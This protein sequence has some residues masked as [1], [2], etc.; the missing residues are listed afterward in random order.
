MAVLPR[1]AW[2]R[3]AISDP[4][5][6]QNCISCEIRLRPRLF[7]IDRLLWVL[8]PIAAALS[9]RDGVGQAG[10]CRPIAPSWIPPALAMAFEIRAVWL[11]AKD[12]R[13]CPEFSRGTSEIRNRDKMRT[14][15]RFGPNSPVSGAVRDANR[16]QNAQNPGK[17]CGESLNAKTVW[18][19]GVD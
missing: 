16:A 6:A 18:R 1:P 10:H 2:R 7:A 13:F 11:P 3:R 9:G 5:S 12:E 14:Y 8:L 15:S 17:P 4:V 19:R